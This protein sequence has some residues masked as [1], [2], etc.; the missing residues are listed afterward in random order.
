MGHIPWKIQAD[1]NLPPGHFRDMKINI[2][3]YMLAVEDALKDIDD[4]YAGAVGGS[5]HGDFFEGLDQLRGVLNETMN[6]CKHT[7]DVVEGMES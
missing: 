3:G 5:Y 1:P 6:Q 7:L 2:R 4:I